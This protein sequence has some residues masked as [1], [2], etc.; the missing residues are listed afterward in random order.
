MFDHKGVIRVPECEIDASTDILEVAI[1][2]GA[3][4]VHAD[5][6]VNE[7]DMTDELSSDPDYTDKQSTDDQQYVKF[8]C[9]PSELTAVSKALQSHG[10]TVTSANLEY[11]PKSLVSLNKESYENALKL[12]Y[13]LCEHSNVTEVYDNFTLE[14]SLKKPSLPAD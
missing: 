9:M 7:M 6:E 11:L 10:Y 4:D 12:V 2:A 13:A 5:R 1:E 14:S 8:I 3:E